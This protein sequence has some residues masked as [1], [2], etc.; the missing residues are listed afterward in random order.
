ML[1]TAGFV[2]DIMFSH[3]EPNTD[4]GWESVMLRIIYHGSP[5]G[6]TKLHNGAN[7]TIAD[8]FVSVRFLLQCWFL[9]P[10]G[11]PAY[12]RTCLQDL[13]F[14]ISCYE[15]VTVWQPN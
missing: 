6:T 9:Y 5:G 12:H 15:M 4:T 10:G 7:S 8:C 13:S 14:A 2:D 3:K 11:A 1:C